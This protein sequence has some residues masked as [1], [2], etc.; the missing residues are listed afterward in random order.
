MFIGILTHKPYSYEVLNI[1][2][3]FQSTSI[4]VTTIS[5]FK[6]FFKEKF[7]LVFTRCDV[8]NLDSSLAIAYFNVLQKLQELETLVLNGTIA[9]KNTQNKLTTHALL[10]ENQIA[11][12]RSWTL[13]QIDKFNKIEYPKVIKSICGGRGENVFFVKKK[14]IWKLSFLI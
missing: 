3:A 12:P 4:Q 11:T 1:I 10:N 5:P 2:K 6:Y 13:D 8:D 14:K 7:D 9:I